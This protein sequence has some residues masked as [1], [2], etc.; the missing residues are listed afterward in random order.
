MAKTTAQTATQAVVAAPAPAPDAPPASD[1]GGVVLL[2][3]TVGALGIGLWQWRRRNMMFAAISGAVSLPLIG[4]IVCGWYSDPVAAQHPEARSAA[5]VAGAAC[6]VNVGCAGASAASAEWSEVLGAGSAERRI[7]D[8]LAIRARI[9]AMCKA[10]PAVCD[11][12][13]VANAAGA[14][15]Q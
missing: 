8:L 7:V 3:L 9:N 5:I 6:L 4:L 15:E 13:E 11:K 2:A 1:F 14:G 10:D 12:T